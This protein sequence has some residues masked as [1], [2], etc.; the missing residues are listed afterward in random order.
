MIHSSVQRF[1]DSLIHR[2]LW[3]IHCFIHSLSH[4]CIESFIIGSLNHWFIVSLT[5]WFVDSLIHWFVDSLVYW[6]IQG[7][8]RGF[9]QVISLYFIGATTTTCS[10]VDTPRN[11]ITSLLVHLKVFPKSH[12]FLIVFFSETSAPARAERWLITYDPLTNWGETPSKM[13]NQ[14]WAKPRLTINQT[15]AL[16]NVSL[17]IVILVAETTI[18]ALLTR[19]FHH[20]DA[21]PSTNVGMAVASQRRGRLTMMWHNHT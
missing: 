11:F 1:L 18:W 21:W 5:Q 2:N 13:S 14:N 9:C 4:W 20:Q 7:A 15:T 10:V 12:W 17:R 8:L 3:L 19:A 16:L 6:F